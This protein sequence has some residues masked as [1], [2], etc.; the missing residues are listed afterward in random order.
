MVYA[1]IQSGGK[2]YRVSPGQLLLE[3]LEG[4]VGQEVS[5]DRVLLV[6]GEEGAV[7][8]GRPTV[9]SARVVG[10]IREQGKGEKVV[11]FK[12]KRRKGYRRK[13]GH[14]QLYTGVHIDS[15][16]VEGRAVQKV[17]AA[18][19]PARRKAVKAAEK[20][21]AEAEKAAPP[22]KLAKKAVKKKEAAA[23][24]PAQAASKAPAKT[25]AK[26]ETKKKASRSPK[27]AAP[28]GPEK[29]SKGKGK[30]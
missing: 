18:E 13:R 10:T 23:K 27:K 20:P 28:K 4:E 8:L 5:F 21:V 2:Q 6:S 17:E 30:E 24:E 3:R 7:Q 14:R 9:G 25:K 15:I 29:S 19:K 26:T 11:V 16:E 1:I 22:E 12:F